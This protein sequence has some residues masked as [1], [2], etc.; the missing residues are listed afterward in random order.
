M[1]HVTDIIPLVN[2]TTM[3]SWTAI[4]L[5]IYDRISKNC[6]MFRR[7]TRKYFRFS[8]D[9]N[10]TMHIYSF[11]TNFY[12]HIC[13][14]N[15]EQTLILLYFS[16]FVWKQ[17]QQNQKLPFP[18]WF[19]SCYNKKSK[20]KTKTKNPETYSYKILASEAIAG[21]DDLQ[22]AAKIILESTGLDPD[23]YRLGNT[24]ACVHI[25][26]LCFRS[27]TS[28]HSEWQMAELNDPHPPQIPHL[29][30]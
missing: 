15:K 1:N 7:I 11:V 9:T 20:T 5:K 10:T 26:S 24:K 14:K 16:S 25:Y 4:N 12:Y 22:K 6:S 18:S 28:F 30:D 8:V 27:K 19:Y 2:T 23:S 13:L 29:I 21:M 3:F 17:T